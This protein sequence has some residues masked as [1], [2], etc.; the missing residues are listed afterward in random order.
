MP[1]PRVRG[2]VREKQSAQGWQMKGFPDRGGGDGKSFCKYGRRTP[3][4]RQAGTGEQEKKGR[5]SRSPGISP[6]R[7]RD[8]PKKLRD[9]ET[10][11]HPW[12]TSTN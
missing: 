6:D 1:A 10:H 11:F 9:P 2:I 5:D 7:K 3:D 12:V 8:E 4:N